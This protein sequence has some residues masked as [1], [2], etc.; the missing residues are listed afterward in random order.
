MVFGVHFLHIQI[1]NVC[2]IDLFL[3][4]GAGCEKALGILCSSMHNMSVYDG[5]SFK[6]WP[7]THLTTVG[8]K[9]VVK[10]IFSTL[11]LMFFVSIV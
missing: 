4:R 5:H 11:L 2:V 1:E 8:T 10:D 6:I 9:S 3:Y 7:F